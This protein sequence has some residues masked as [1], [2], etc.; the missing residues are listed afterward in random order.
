MLE[1]LGCSGSSTRSQRRHGPRERGPS[2]RASR[3]ADRDPGAGGARPARLASV[4]DGDAAGH[5]AA[6]WVSARR[7]RVGRALRAR[8][9]ARGARLRPPRL[10]PAARHTARPDRRPAAGGGG[11]G[12]GHARRG[13]PA[14]ER[15][16]TP[17]PRRTCRSLRGDGDAA[18][19]A[20]RRALDAATDGADPLAGADDGRDGRA[21]RR[22]RRS[23]LRLGRHRG[24]TRLAG[25]A[26]P[27]RPGPAA[28]CLAARVAGVAP[29]PDRR[30]RGA[31]SHR[32]GDAWDEAGDEAG[33]DAPGPVA[34]TVRPVLW[35]ALAA[36][37]SPRSRSCRRCGRIP[38][39][40]GAGGAGR[41]PRPGGSARRVCPRARRR[42]PRRA[43]PLA[44]LAEDSD[45]QVAA[46]ATATRERLQGDAAA[47]PL[48]AARRVPGAPRGLGARR[49]E[50]A[51]SDLRR[52][53]SGSCSSRSR[54]GARGRLVRGLLGRQA[55]RHGA[56]EPRR[57]DLARPQGA[58]PARSAEQSVIELSERTYRLRLRER[59]SVD[60]RP[61]RGGRAGRP[62]GSRRGSA[63]LARA[64][65]RSL[66]RRA[67]AGGS[68]RRVVLRL[69]GAPGRG[70]TPGARRPDRD[71]RRF[72]GAARG[73][74]GCAPAPRDRPAQRG[75][76]PAADAHLTRAPGGP[77]RPCA[78][79]SS[80]GGRSSWSSV[81]SRPRRPPACRHA[82]WPASRSE[83]PPVATGAS[84]LRQ[85]IGGIS[86]F[87][88]PR[89]FPQ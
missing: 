48:R 24:D 33:C 36:G 88:F 57:G 87:S 17:R 63:G 31:A 3:P 38:G 65:G 1:R 43:R 4:R 45:E 68:L 25:R 73:D 23:G 82:S 47:A 37:R 80:A 27:R 53:W 13:A 12:P 84:T 30:A 35:H 54:G 56:P 40:R 9:G 8:G 16:S 86:R 39:R 75:R 59:D 6:T 2:R 89:A 26:L 49:G 20:A 78:S 42:P 67:A 41:S 44:E 69:A 81:S 7:P 18:I 5:P 50:L 11:A 70:P 22:D 72:G 77:A 29:V 14:G 55:G 10:P 74:Q 21:P 76:P 51:A 79:S 28:P 19:E 71:L 58:R 60:V 66:G 61:V 52:A 15:C 85:L 32:S 83:R 34:R 46:A 64:R 62:G